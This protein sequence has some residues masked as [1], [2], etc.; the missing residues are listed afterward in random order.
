MNRVEQRKQ[1]AVQALRELVKEKSGTDPGADLESWPSQ[2]RELIQQSTK[3]PE[4]RMRHTMA[5]ICEALRLRWSDEFPADHPYQAELDGQ[6][7]K[8]DMRLAVVELVA[9]N[10]KQLRG[11]FLDLLTHPAANKV[12]V[13]GSAAA[14][15]PSKALMH[16]RK[17]VELLSAL[18]GQSRVTIFTEEELRSDPSILGRF[19]EPA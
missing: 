7:F 1:H 11:D 16:A 18:V 15:D 8:G 10:N 5:T 3:E 19:L 4:T 14:C 2:V 17:V 6:I 12:L 13:V 9:K